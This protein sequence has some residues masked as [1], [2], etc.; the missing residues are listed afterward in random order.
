V[1]DTYI[2]LDNTK[3]FDQNACADLNRVCDDGQ[4]RNHRIWINLTFA[5][6]GPLPLLV[7]NKPQNVRNRQPRIGN[8]QNDACSEVSSH[9]AFS[10]DDNA[11]SPRGKRLSYHVCYGFVNE[12]ET[13]VSGRPERGQSF[14]DSVAISRKSDG[15]PDFRFRKRCMKHVRLPHYGVACNN[16]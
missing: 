11:V 10:R 2:V 8:F 3:R 12:I 7:H 13:A 5:Y 9:G 4:W 1:S 6:P 15:S 14:D 16:R